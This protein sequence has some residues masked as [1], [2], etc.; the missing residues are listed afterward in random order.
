MKYIYIIGFVLIISC[1]KQNNNQIKSH[2]INLDSLI[3]SLNTQEKKEKFLV[4]LFQQDQNVRNSD[5]ENE[6]LKRNN[7][8]VDSSEYQ[9]Y[10]RRIKEV[11]SLNYLSILKYLKEY[12]YPVFKS[13]NPKVIPA[14]RTVC[15]HQSFNKQLELFPYLYK[16]YNDG[17]INSEEFSFLLNRMHIMKYGESYP[18]AISYEENIE[19]LLEKLQL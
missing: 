14:I 1:S 5:R 9:D 12:G 16:A 19:Q 11:D 17:F 6:I 8:N 3:T 2:S 10:R 18:H 7:Y 15:L 4:N 13:K